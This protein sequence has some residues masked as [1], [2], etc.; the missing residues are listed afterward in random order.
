MDVATFGSTSSPCSAQYI[1]NKNAQAYAEQYP[2]AVEAIV[3]KHY[4]DDYLDSTDAVDQ[5]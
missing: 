5:L 4:V 2:D 1:K 3:D